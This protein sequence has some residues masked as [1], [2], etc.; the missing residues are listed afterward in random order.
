MKILSSKKWE[1]INQKYVDM[2]MDLETQKD[3]NHKYFCQVEVLRKQVDDLKKTNDDIRNQINDLVDSN[4]ALIS[5]NT[6]LEDTIVGKDKEIR[7]LKGLLTK[8]KV[9]YKHLYDKE[10]KNGRNQTK[11]VHHK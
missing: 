6:S 3:D 1:E 8:N 10:N 4:T 7:T 5:R 9:D 2:Q 11:N